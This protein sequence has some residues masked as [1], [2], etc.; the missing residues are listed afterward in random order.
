MYWIFFIVIT[1]TISQP[2]NLTWFNFTYFNISNSTIMLNMTD[3][4]LTNSTIN[5]TLIPLFTTT[6]EFQT[7]FNYH[8]T[9]NDILPNDTLSIQIT[10][11]FNYDNNSIIYDEILLFELT[12]IFDNL[13]NQTLI[14]NGYSNSNDILYLHPISDTTN[15]TNITQNNL[16]IT[17]NIILLSNDN[18]HEIID[19]LSEY[20][21]TNTFIQDFNNDLEQEI[22]QLINVQN[23]EIF[24][25]DPQISLS[26]TISPQD[27]FNT[28][29]NI[30]TTEIDTTEIKTTENDLTMLTTT[31]FDDKEEEENEGTEYVLPQHLREYML[32]YVILF[33]ILSITC[34]CFICWFFTVKCFGTD[35]FK[36]CGRNN[37][38]KNERMK[39]RKNGKFEE[40]QSYND[41]NL[42][43]RVSQI[44]IDIN[45]DEAE[46]VMKAYDDDAVVNDKWYKKNKKNE[47]ER[48]NSEEIQ[49]IPLNNSDDENM[50]LKQKMDIQNA[51]DE[52]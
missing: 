24:G 37:N 15:N 30:D 31:D 18:Q 29:F 6:T 25:Y 41:L 34:L 7:S 47:D 40:T 52:D 26:S 12:E 27:T 19:I 44:D 43:T 17:W 32:L 49:M 22:I 14:N 50:T 36:I 20:I 33:S 11:N 42:T 13:L 46:F 45:N 16:Y 38:E 10:L 5:N 2:L 21:L 35:D 3:F 9:S 39:Y 23:M 48:E 51:F 1:V 8:T 4:N 28:T